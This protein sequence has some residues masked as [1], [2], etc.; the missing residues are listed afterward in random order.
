MRRKKRV[1]QTVC[2]KQVAGFFGM[3]RFDSRTAREPANFFQRAR[4]AGGVACELYRRGVGQHL[5]LTANS[6]LDQSSEEYACRSNDNQRQA[7]T[8]QGI[9]PCTRAE[10]DAT[11]NSQAKNPKDQP[12]Q[13]QIESHIAIED[14]TELVSNNSLQ[15]VTRKK[16]HTAAR[17]G[18]GRIARGMPRSEC[19]DS[20]LVV[21]D[22]HLRDRQ[23]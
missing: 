16:F 5:T 7:N 11:D 2:E 6:S 20:R 1:A 23:T 15:F 10:E 8:R 14:M 21:H 3:R 4:Q 13:A 9:F 22:V 19:V 18:D 17:H 12:H